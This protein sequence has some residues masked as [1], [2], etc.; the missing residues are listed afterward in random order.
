[1]PALF[2]NAG[3]WPA[4][5]SIAGRP[6]VRHHLALRAQLLQPPRR[7]RL[8][9]AQRGRN[10]LGARASGCHLFNLYGAH[11]VA[12]KK[13]VNTWNLR[14]MCV[15]VQC[16]KNLLFSQLLTVGGIFHQRCP[17]LKM[18]MMVLASLLYT[19]KKKSPMLGTQGKRS[20]KRQGP[21]ANRPPC[22]PLQQKYIHISVLQNIA[23]PPFWKMLFRSTPCDRAPVFSRTWFKAC[24]R[25]DLILR[26]WVPTDGALRIHVHKKVFFK[27]ASYVCSVCLTYRWPASSEPF[28][29]W[30]SCFS[31]GLGILIC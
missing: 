1:M 23:R 17:K 11:H 8:R 25:G 13:R 29:I 6:T 19:R 2:G 28:A 12:R 5:P 30:A 15:D 20:A 27:M 14:Q 10:L 3:R 31:C 24:L 18:F 16:G 21:R 4:D 26:T 9:Q 22:I 7:R